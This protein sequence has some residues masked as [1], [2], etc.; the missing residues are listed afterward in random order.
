MS[1][2][3][4]PALAPLGMQKINWVREFMPVLSSVEQRFIK[5]QPFA[6]LRITVS[7]HAEAKT[8]Y[9]AM[10]LRSGGAEVFVTTND[11]SYGSKG[12]VTDAMKGLDYDYVFTCGPMPMLKAVYSACEDGQFSFEERMACGIGACM[13]CSCES[14]YGAKRICKDGPVLFREEIIW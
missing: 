10:V 1:N 12:F 7:V 13:A 11:G 3:K 2:I 5:E 4:N 14:K 8:A 6:G 9:L